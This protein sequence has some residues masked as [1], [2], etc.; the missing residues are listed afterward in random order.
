MNGC[1]SCGLGVGSY[2]RG[3]RMCAIKGLPNT[4]NCPCQICLIKVVCNKFCKKRDE[5]R[6]DNYRYDYASGVVEFI[7]D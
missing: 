2:Y 4:E 6:T 3:K 5:F 1:D 7:H